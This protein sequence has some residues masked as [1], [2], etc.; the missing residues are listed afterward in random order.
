MLLLSMHIV[1]T[2]DCLQAKSN[3]PGLR[4]FWGGAHQPGTKRTGANRSA[5]IQALELLVMD[6]AERK[7][8]ASFQ[9]N[10]VAAASVGDHALH[11][12]GVHEIGP[13]DSLELGRK[14]FPQGIQGL[15]MVFRNTRLEPD[16]DII[17]FAP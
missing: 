4:R 1:T 8:H 14:D 3:P 10:I 12:P 17:P 13:V 5:E 15:T 9:F 2:R 6:S 16:F 7:F 11:I